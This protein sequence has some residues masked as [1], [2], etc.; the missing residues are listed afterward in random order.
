ME[1]VV[2]GV[3]DRE[4]GKDGFG[5]TD[6]KWRWVLKTI[7]VV[8]GVKDGYWIKMLLD[9]TDVLTATFSLFGSF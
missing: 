7:R 3:K 9:V 6:G 5:F 4:V 1:R 2:L 8:L